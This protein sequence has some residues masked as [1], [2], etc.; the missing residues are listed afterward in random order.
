MMLTPILLALSLSVMDGHYP[1]GMGE[2]PNPD[3]SE[4]RPVVVELFTSRGC[5][6]AWRQTGALASWPRARV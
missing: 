6:L 4:D 3:H 2:T 5:R 1:A